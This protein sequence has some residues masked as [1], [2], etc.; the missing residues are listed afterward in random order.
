MP[1][2]TDELEADAARGTATCFMLR[3]RAEDP[4]LA[5]E[6]A[7]VLTRPFSSAS[8]I[9]ALQRRGVKLGKEALTTHRRGGCPQCQTS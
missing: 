9:R 1:S 7:T 8:I 2:L 3:L 5:D 4:S 6:V